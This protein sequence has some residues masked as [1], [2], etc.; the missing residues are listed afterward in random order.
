MMAL[1]PSIL[2]FSNL[3]ND[4]RYELWDYPGFGQKERYHLLF[5]VN[6]LVVSDSPYQTEVLART[7]FEKTVEEH[8]Q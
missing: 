6:G 7:I 8:N 4:R 5:L 2:V 1:I 3:H